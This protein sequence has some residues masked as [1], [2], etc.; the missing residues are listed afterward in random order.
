MLGIWNV[1]QNS[2]LT[3]KRPVQSCSFQNRIPSTESIKNMRYLL[4]L[5]LQTLY[6]GNNFTLVQTKLDANQYL[7]ARITLLN[8][9]GVTDYGLHGLKSPFS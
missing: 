9:I 2:L 5:I 1:S 6:L 7:V 3:F 4:S 8:L